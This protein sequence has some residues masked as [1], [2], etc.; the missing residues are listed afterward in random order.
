MEN[1]EM[2]N[3]A[4]EKTGIRYEQAV[5]AIAFILAV[6]VAVWLRF[7]QIGVKP[8]HHDEGVNSHFLLNLANHGEY[9]YN[10][11]NYH[12]PTLYYI[13]LPL[14][15]VLGENDFTLRFTPA[16]FGVLTV[17]MVWFL[18]RRL[19]PIGTPVAAVLMALSP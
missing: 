6:I 17:V 19:G 15:H 12:G 13:V 4:I 5:C 3:E 1:V 10:P 7:D 9:K 8:F 2:D 18:R 11:E 16:L 14:I